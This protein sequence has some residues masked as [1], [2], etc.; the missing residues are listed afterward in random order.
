[1]EDHGPVRRAEDKAVSVEWL[2]G[3]SHIPFPFSPA[4]R[5]SAPAFLPTS[6]C[7]LGELTCSSSLRSWSP[8]HSPPPPPLQK[9]AIL[10]G[11]G[12]TQS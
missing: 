7:A 2:L 6:K 8:G 12:G 4:T 10:M 3:V 9:E 5:N 11:A 1:M